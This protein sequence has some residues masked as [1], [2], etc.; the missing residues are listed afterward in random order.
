MYEGSSGPYSGT[1]LSIPPNYQ[2]LLDKWNRA[3][4]SDFYVIVMSKGTFPYTVS[5]DNTSILGGSVTVPAWGGTGTDYPYAV[6]HFVAFGNGNIG[7]VTIPKYTLCGVSFWNGN[8]ANSAFESPVLALKSAQLTGTAYTL[9]TSYAAVAGGTTSPS[10]TLPIS[11]TYL[12]SYTAQVAF[13]GTTYAA[14][15]EADF[16]LYRTNNTPGA[17]TGTLYDASIPAM[18][19]VTKNGPTVT[20]ASFVYVGTARD[21]LTIYGQIGGAAGA[22][23]VTVPNANLTAQFVSP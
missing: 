18:T 17:I 9:T 4:A 5:C 13:A 19:T 2:G 11:G 20:L 8:G 12:I 23:T 22:G 15:S 1:T 7:V 10:I 21:I 14:F 3:C 6:L 16:E